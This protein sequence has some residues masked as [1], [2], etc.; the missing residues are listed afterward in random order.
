MGGEASVLA[1]NAAF[2]ANDL[3]AVGI[4]LNFGC[5][6]KTVNKHMAGAAL[7]QWPEKLFEITSAVKRALPEDV[8]LSAKMRLGFKDKTLALENAKAL[9][10][11][12]A[13]KLTVH[14]RHQTGRL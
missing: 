12:G 3:K 4:D 13:E 11:A 5:P 9:E 14:A 7:L 1:E 10:E 8:P 2:A 6:A